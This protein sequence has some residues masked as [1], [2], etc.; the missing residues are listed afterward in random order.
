MDYVIN[1]ALKENVTVRAV[2]GQLRLHV[3]I[4]LLLNPLDVWMMHVGTALKNSMG[5]G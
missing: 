1:I 3:N 4:L 5:C 2:D